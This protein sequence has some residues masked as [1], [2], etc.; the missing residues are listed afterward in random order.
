MANLRRTF[1]GGRINKDTDERL[2]QDGEYRHAENVLVL[3]SEGS[4]VGA[5]QNSYSNK[6]LTNI[7]FGGGIIDTTGAYCDEFE[8]KIYWFVNSINGCFL[9]EWNN[10]N[11]VV[12]FVLKDTRPLSTRVLNVTKDFL[13]TGIEK[14]ISEDIKEDLLLWTDNNM[15]PCCINIEHAKSWGENNFVLEDILLIKKPPRYAP[16]L[17]P[18][19][20]NDLANNIEEK[21]LSFSYRYKYHDGEYSALSS[22]TNYSFTP[23]NFELDYYTMDNLG[24]VNSFNAVRINF[25]TGESQ[26][27]D[28]QLAVK[29]SNSNNIY[30]IE[31]FNKKKEDW[32]DGKIKNYTFSNSK[33]YALLPEKELYRAFDNVPLKAKALTLIGNRPVFGNYLEGRDLVDDNGN[34]IH[35]NYD[36]SLINELIDDGADFTVV[37]LQNVMTVANPI[38]ISLLKGNKIIFYFSLSIDADY[39]CYSNSFYYILPEDYATLEDVFA[40]DEFNDFMPIIDNDFRNNYVWESM[41]AGYNVTVDPSITYA[42]V[43]GVPTFTVTPVTFEDTNNANAIVVTNFAYIITSQVSITTTA[44][45]TSAKTNR[46]YEVGIVYEDTFNRKTTV[47]TSLYN[48][49]Y[50]PQ[51]YSIFKNRIKVTLNHKPPVWADRYKIVVKAQPLQYQTIYVNKFYNE[52]FHV[53]CKLEAENKDKVKVGDT[54][55]VKKAAEN[56]LSNP[57][58]IKVLAIEEK[59]KDF[60]VGNTDKNGN[61]II[62][63]YGFYMKIRPDKFSM[64]FDNYEIKQNYAYACTNGGFPYAFLDLQ[65]TITT[66]GAPPISTLTELSIPIGSSVYLYIK[67]NRKYSSGWKDNIYEYTHYAQRD[68]DTI[69]DW[70]NENIMNRYLPGNIGNDNQDYRHNIE[71]VRGQAEQVFFGPF[72]HYN[73]DPDPSGK[74]Y[75]KIKG[76]FSGAQERSGRVEAKIVVRT[77]TGFYVFETEPK[78]ADNDIFYET[79]QTFD[80]LDGNHQANIQNQ[81]VSSLIPAIIDLDFFNCYTQGNGVESYRIKDGFNKNYLN[82]D[83]RPSTTS[84]EEYKGVRRYADLTYG[85]PFVES[86]NMNGLNVFNLSTVN[87]KELDKQYGSIQKLHSRDN[88]ILV[89][90]EEKASKVMFGK[91]ALYNG[92]GTVNVTSTAQV[93][94]QQVTYLG[95]NGIGKNPESF[96]VNDYQIFYANLRRG[97]IQRLS[98]DGV[99]NIID[100]MVDWFRDLSISQP[101]AKKLGCYDPYLNQYVLSVDEEPVVIYDLECGNTIVKNN[102]RLPFTYHLNLNEL[103]GD[104]VLNYNITQGNAT[105]AAVFNGVVSVASNV[106][107]VGNLTIPRTTLNSNVVEITITPVSDEISYEVTNICPLGI[108]LKV[109]SVILNDYEDIGKT[110]TNRY[111]WGTSSFYSEN[112]LFG[113]APISR[114]SS[115][116]GIEGQGRIP[117]RGSI[118]NMQS[119]KD[120]MASGNFKTSECNRIGYLVSNTTYTDLDINTI[121]SLATFITPDQVIDGLVNEIYSG[122]FLFNRTSENEI[123]YLVWDYTNRK[124][125]LVNDN[126]LVDG[127]ETVVLSVLDNDSELG[128]PVVTII[129][130]PQ[131]GIAIVNIDNTITYTNNGNANLT[132]AIVYQVSNGICSSFATINIS[133]SRCVSLYSFDYKTSNGQMNSTVTFEYTP[134]DHSANQQITFSLPSTNAQYETYLA[135][136]PCMI[137]GTLVRVT[138]LSNVTNFEYVECSE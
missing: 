46:D 18:T 138:G 105:I 37:C 94:G 66:V 99:T 117:H 64:D 8:D 68:Y 73:Y 55:I 51:Q 70:F 56:V 83:L 43:S 57:I 120:S 38:P 54:L 91:D 41:P 90:Q 19:Y 108:P 26:V 119:F 24:M 96:A 2:L 106:N 21:F 135:E 77:N 133:I 31:T 101:N 34:K 113:E 4:D 80:I 33:L 71:L 6:Q 134:C 89:L 127:G 22:Y 102:Q 63:E 15:Q 98:I 62:E 110:I 137:Y 132:D 109:V 114:F 27:T 75:L 79:E 100:G 92:D 128:T 61:P 85:D 7:D 93:L 5:V 35:V 124:P 39:P 28:I 87:Y 76:T 16:I 36:L 50:V 111:R 9:M 97:L 45:A 81:E 103:D 25:N 10:Q 74:L 122:N 107:S 32:K 1:L 121:L 115:E 136:G 17:I 30:I 20:Q 47:L 86:S 104:I 65:T 112:D 58:K 129:T 52:D 126:Y 67:S 53:W 49:I 42:L 82:I 11:E 116:Y 125:I 12:S 84:I 118:V 48:T 14:I 23:K 95:E 131:N 29:E 40:T 3:N 78:Q 60:I 88:D 130:G 69:E 72:A 123:L 44:N 13:I 59:K